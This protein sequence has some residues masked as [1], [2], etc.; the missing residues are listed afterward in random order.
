MSFD[1]HQC[2]L[3]HMYRNI[4]SLLILSLIF[5]VTLSA[6]R[7]VEATSGVAWQVRGSWHVDGKDAAISSG[8]YV[9]AGSL[10]HAG[11]QDASNSI[12]VLLPDGQ[13]ILYECFTQ[14]D[15]SR[16]FRVP[17]L[18]STPEPLA[19]DLLARI[20]ESLV[21][22]SIG[23][24]GPTAQQGL[25][26]PRDEQVAVLDSDNR[27]HVEGLAARLSNGHYT[28]DLRPLDRSHPRQFQLEFE[29]NGPSITL[30]VPSAGLY[31][32]TVRDA[33]NRS[34]IDLFVAAVEPARAANVAKCY[35]DGAAL[36]K[37]WNT[38]YLGWPVHDFQRAYLT[39]LM[40]SSDALP[41]NGQAA[42]KDDTSSH[43][44]SPARV[45]NAAE[46]RTRVAA[47]PVFAPK[48]GLFDKEV[49]V[50]LQCKTPGATIH[51]TVDGSQPVSKS[52]VYQA[53]II[54][55]TSVLT[56]KSYASVAGRKDSPVVTGI[57]RIKE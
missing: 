4:L 23:A 52:P 55:K 7:Q 39:S 26:L 16:G 41:K 15:C 43:A 37:E 1:F 14:E 47:E 45:T 50:A 3:A 6:Q 9:P 19:V 24:A 11:A 48:P 34:R 17:A 21:A 12:T 27:V 36:M 56:V 38:Y 25:R 20:H 32:V 30:A 29:K 40:L 31:F 18:F 53:P 42:A 44:G 5:A 33:L 35:H 10:L 8:D 28:Y 57:F 54:V 49:A 13:L 46:D 51:F 22:S 2:S